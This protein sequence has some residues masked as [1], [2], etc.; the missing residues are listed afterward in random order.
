MLEDQRRAFGAGK[1]TV[2]MTM[3][4]YECCAR[5]LEDECQRCDDHLAGTAA[6]EKTALSKVAKWPNEGGGTSPSYRRLPLRSLRGYRFLADAV[7]DFNRS[8]ACYGR[9]P[10]KGRSLEAASSSRSLASIASRRAYIT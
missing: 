5:W 10:G 4:D 2:T 3:H 6:G 9:G 8:S 7:A 1:E